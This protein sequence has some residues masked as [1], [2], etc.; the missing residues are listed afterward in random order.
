MKHKSIK[1]I[2]FILALLLV[3]PQCG[4]LSVNA[5]SSSK[6]KT[7]YYK[8]PDEWKGRVDANTGEEILP[9][10][11]VAGGTDG[12]HVP[13][14]GE[15]MTLVDE[16]NDIWSYTIPGDGMI[17]L[18]DNDAGTKTATG[19]WEPYNTDEPRVAISTGVFQFV[20]DVT[21]NLYCY[22]CDNAY[23]TVDGG[24]AVTFENGQSA[25]I[26][27]DTAPLSSTN[28]TLAK[29]STTALPDNI[30]SSIN[31]FLLYFF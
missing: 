22:N 11:Y 21:I 31:N 16:A 3:I 29:R 27:G 9:A 28:I 8:L 1:A 20:G 15:H 12:Q 23:Y 5:A 7:V 19:H 24:E 30:N 26:G 17:F 4:V 18:I 2:S 10:A 25:T 13:W 14:V 6:G